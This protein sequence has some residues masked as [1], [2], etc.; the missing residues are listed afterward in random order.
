M[1]VIFILFRKKNGLLHAKKASFSGSEESLFYAEII[2]DMINM[3]H[4]LLEK[5]SPGFGRFNHF[6]AFGKRLTGTCF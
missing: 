2:L 4:F 6:D 5:V 1:Q 3:D